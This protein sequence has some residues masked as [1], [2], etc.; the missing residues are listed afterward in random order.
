MNSKITEKNKKNGVKQTDETDEIDL[1]LL[2]RHFFALQI[3]LDAND[4]EFNRLFS[5]G[6]ISKEIQDTRKSNSNISKTEIDSKK[7]TS[8]PEN[9]ENVKKAT[10]LIEEKIK[11]KKDRSKNRV[12]NIRKRTDDADSITNSNQEELIK[13]YEEEDDWLYRL[14]TDEFIRKK[15]TGETERKT[16]YNI[17]ANVEGINVDDLIELSE[18]IKKKTV[19]RTPVELFNT[20]VKRDKNDVETKVE[21]ELHVDNFVKSIFKIAKETA[22][23][24]ENDKSKSTDSVIVKRLF[25]FLEYILDSLSPKYGEVPYRKKNKENI[26]IN[27][28]D[29][30]HDPTGR[31]KNM[32][33][34]I[35]S[36]PTLTKIEQEL[37]IFIDDK[38]VSTDYRYKNIDRLLRCSK[39]FRS[40][41]SRIILPLFLNIN[42]TVLTNH[43][44]DKDKKALTYNDVI[45]HLLNGESILKLIKKD[46]VLWRKIEKLYSEKNTSEL[47]KLARKTVIN[48]INYL[49]NNLFSPKG[50]IFTL[51]EEPNYKK[52]TSKDKTWKIKKFSWSNKREIGNDLTEKLEQSFNNIDKDSLIAN[53]KC[54]SSIVLGSNIDNDDSDSQSNQ[55]L[56][57]MTPVV[58]ITLYPDNCS[59]SEIRKNNCKETL[60]TINVLK[61]EYLS[62][63]KGIKYKDSGN[64]S[65]RKRN[66]KNLINQTK[67]TKLE[68]KGKRKN[69]E[70]IDTKSKKIKIGG[71]L[72]KMTKK[73]DKLYK[74]TVK[75]MKQKRKKQTKKVKYQK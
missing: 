27:S 46:R 10:T 37:K 40:Y 56:T 5:K 21:K 73:K 19:F 67:G 11:I 17:V 65:K 48:N 61:E 8:D 35:V 4:D 57:D 49:V 24:K 20:L 41:N 68:C 18:F 16:F 15:I 62:N 54:D 60:T 53:S 38:T 70:K 47:S 58:K 69:L 1:A 59:S 63:A 6:M 25:D 31:T 32:P 36:I 74:K 71:G 2:E 50:Y 43:F 34:G 23:Y 52:L 3:R 66:R 45:T 12:E 39:R 42:A 33:M 29:I 30:L 51:P 28:N 9:A 14:I 55:L 75:L 7:F 72:R 26:F 13:F 64:S 44:L 22:L